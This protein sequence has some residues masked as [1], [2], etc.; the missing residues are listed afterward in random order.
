MA[1]P[2]PVIESRYQTVTDSR[3]TQEHH[4][5]LLLLSTIFQLVRQNFSLR[6]YDNIKYPSIP[7]N[8]R[9]GMYMSENH[10]V[11]YGKNTSLYVRSPY[12]VSSNGDM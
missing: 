11:I 12:Q 4:P 3:G 7:F 6:G 10:E 1:C 8:N 5:P 2:F 9:G